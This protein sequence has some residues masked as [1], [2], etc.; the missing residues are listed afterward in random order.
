MENLDYSRLENTLKY[1]NSLSSFRHED[2][3]NDH[4]LHSL[5]E[6][7]SADGLN[8]NCETPRSR[9][10]GEMLK[11]SDSQFVTY[12]ILVMIC[13]LCAAA[14]NGLTQVGFK[15]VFFLNRICRDY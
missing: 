15:E 14:A 3:P 8:F 11:P 1:L 7:L 10:L 9:F 6:S 5:F 13:I 2:I 12:I 4:L